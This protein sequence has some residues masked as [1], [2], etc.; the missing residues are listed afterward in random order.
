[1]NNEYF[2]SE[3]TLK[4]NSTIVKTIGIKFAE[5]GFKKNHLV[6]SLIKYY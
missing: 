4:E 6:K 1:M 3:I 5:N 2:K